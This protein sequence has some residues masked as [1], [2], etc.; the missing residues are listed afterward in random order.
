MLS[1]G[2]GLVHGTIPP[3]GHEDVALVLAT[4][5]AH[6]GRR[7]ARRHLEAMSRGGGG[8]RDSRITLRLQEEVAGVEVRAPAV[9]PGKAATFVSTHPEGDR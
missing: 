7:L 9:D 2:T 8:N 6:V 3:P 5:R 4:V 1:G